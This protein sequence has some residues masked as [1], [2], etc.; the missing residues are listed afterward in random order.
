MLISAAAVV[1]SSLSAARQRQYLAGIAATGEPV[2]AQGNWHGFAPPRICQNSLFS[3]HLPHNL[4]KAVCRLFH[5]PLWRPLAKRCSMTTTGENENL[6]ETA[7]LEQSHDA[8]IGRLFRGLIHNLNGAIQAFSLHAE[9]LGMAFQQAGQLLREMADELPEDAARES[10]L[11]LQELFLRRTETVDQMMDK[12]RT[13]QMIMKNTQALTDFKKSLSGEGYTV[14]AA[15]QAEIEFLSAD[16]FFK[17]KVE[18]ELR[19]ADEM[20]AVRQLHVELHELLFIFLANALEAMEL[21]DEPHLL[22]ES[23][24][25]GKW[26]EIVI[27][28]SGCG[29]PVADQE[30]IF[31]PFFTTKANHRGLG[32][33]LARKIMDR[34]NGE[35]RSLSKPGCT[36]FVLSLPIDR[37]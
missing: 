2:A 24:T 23:A 6:W 18:K 20:P 27:Q 13:A 31:S 21:G 7:Y 8:A 36:R 17:H 1:K 28:D 4:L 9:L 35:I 11:K 37:I 14:N 10:A 19:L 25:R 30:K 32:L 26:L 29:I 33:Y 34:C 22:V 12:V 15:I 3:F 16:S 5:H